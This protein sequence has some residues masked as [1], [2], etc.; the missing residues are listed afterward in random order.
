MPRLTVGL[1][2]GIAS[3]KSLVSDRFVELGVP[4][5]DA[6]QVARDV[7]APGSPALQEIAT[8]F[9]RQYLL[10]DGQ[11]DRRKM[12]ERVFSDPAS[13]QTLEAITHPHIRQRMRTWRDAQASAYCILSVAIL[14]ESGM[15]ELV[16]RVLVVDALPESQ[17]QRLV[18]RDNISATLAEQ[19]IQAQASR[20]ERL[21]A[22]HDVVFN[23]GSP[24]IARA[25]VDELHAFYLSI[26]RNGE[27]YAR[28]L[29]LPKALT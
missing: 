26:A 1:T 17:L 27:I 21:A 13:R 9:G 23:N 7:V 20:Q 29:C 14:V 18:G 22:A 4:V 5:L 16:D 11:L 15:R 24:A 2:G 6:D 19:M 12:R 25:A 10:A 28:G 3:G 8:V